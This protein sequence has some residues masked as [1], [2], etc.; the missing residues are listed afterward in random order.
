MAPYISVKLVPHAVCAIYESRNPTPTKLQQGQPATNPQ[1]ILLG[2]NSGMCG[3]QEA[4]PQLLKPPSL[5]YCVVNVLVFFAALYLSSSSKLVPRQDPVVFLFPHSA[6]QCLL[7]HMPVQMTAEQV[8][9]SCRTPT[10]RP[11][12][13]QFECG[14]DE[15]D[16]HVLAISSGKNNYSWIRMLDINLPLSPECWEFQQRKRILHPSST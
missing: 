10:A 8:S 11:E 5:W 13:L 3:S 1:R 14:W 2:M 15:K 4:L 6:G 7:H 16:N 12:L 9:S